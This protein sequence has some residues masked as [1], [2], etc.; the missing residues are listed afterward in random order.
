MITRFRHSQ[1]SQFRAEL[2]G[3]DC[4]D[5]RGYHGHV[6]DLIRI[7]VFVFFKVDKV[8]VAIRGEL[9]GVIEHGLATQDPRPHQW[10]YAATAHNRELEDSSIAVTAV[11]HSSLRA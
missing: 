7:D 2:L 11:G 10:I 9:A 8:L 1:R 5:T 6:G 3:A 4:V